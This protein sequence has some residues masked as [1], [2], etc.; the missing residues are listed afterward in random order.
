MLLIA[1]KFKLTI[2]YCQLMGYQFGKAMALFALLGLVAELHFL[3][4]HL[5]Q[6]T[7]D[8]RTLMISY[9]QSSKYRA[10]GYHGKASCVE[11]SLITFVWPNLATYCMYLILREAERV[12]WL[13]GLDWQCDNKYTKSSMRAEGRKD[14]SKRKY[15]QRLDISY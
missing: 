5:Y 1:G 14:Q 8:W 10:L 7:N 2:F 11:I 3:A 15:F 13:I 12:I 9:L 6:Y 4:F